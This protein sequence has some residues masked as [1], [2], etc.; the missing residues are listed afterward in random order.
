MLTHHSGRDLG[1]RKERE[2]IL[3]VT[4]EYYL[5]MWTAPKGK[6]CHV[7]NENLTSIDSLTTP[8]EAV[9]KKTT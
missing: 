4:Q 1:M 5:L 2:I 9:I 6:K 7:C 3:F 8:V